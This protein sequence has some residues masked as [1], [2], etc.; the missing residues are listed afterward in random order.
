LYAFTTGEVYSYSDEG[1]PD[2]D[3]VIR[4]LK[5]YPDGHIEEL[6]LAG[7]RG[8]GMAVA[9]MN[10]QKLV[11]D[12]EKA[13]AI[14]RKLAPGAS[15]FLRTCSIAYTETDRARLQRLADALG[16]KV[17]G[18]TNETYGPGGGAKGKYI[19]FT[20]GEAMPELP[21]GSGAMGDP[22]PSKKKK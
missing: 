18:N 19:E 21:S 9:H 12:P 22:K 16:V 10:L 7:H 2:I 6:V 11:D 17:I 3:E 14:S 13:R 20:P 15:V 1:K 5:D 4:V 8:E